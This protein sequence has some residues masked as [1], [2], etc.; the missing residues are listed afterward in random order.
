MLSDPKDTL[1]YHQSRVFTT[2]RDMRHIQCANVA[3]ALTTFKTDD[4]LTSTKPETEALYFYGLNHA[5]ALIA[6]RRALLE[7][8][9]KEELGFVE[10]YHDLM[11]EKS[12]RAFY[13]LV[14][15]CTREARHC[16]SKSTAKPEIEKK[17]GKE[18]AAF[19][20]SST[21]SESD[22]HQKFLKNPPKATIGA[23]CETMQWL[24]YNASWSGGYGGKAWGKVTDCLVRFVNGEFTAEMMMDTVWTLC[25]NNGPIFNKGHLYGMYTN[26][27]VRILDIQRSGQIPQAILEDA[28]IAQFVDIGLKMAMQDLQKMFPDD[29]GKFVDWFVVEALGAVHKYPADKQAQ[30]AKYGLSEKATQAEK[31]QAMKTAAAAAAA[32]AAAEKEAKEFLTIM[33]GVKVKKIVMKRAA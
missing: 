10:I 6:G 33:P 30:I 27:L 4:K 9:P 5:T 2:H 16:L 26:N 20:C 23:Y 17:F 7:P 25:H 21:G 19:F 22:I 32:K 13:Y 14:L 3:A 18:L 31:E 8:L 12:V 15:I 1:A 28:K 24:Y 11:I 29:I